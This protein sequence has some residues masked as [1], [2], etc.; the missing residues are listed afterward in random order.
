MTRTQRIKA[1]A[2]RR[3]SR[4]AR[5]EENFTRPLTPGRAGR[6][7]QHETALAYNETQRQNAN[8]IRGSAQ[9]EKQV[10]DWYKTFA[11]E[12]AAS[13]NEVSGAYDKAGQA[14]Q[15]TM[16]SGAAADSARQAQLGQEAAQ[17]SQL[18]GAPQNTT[19]RAT[20]AAAANG[21]QIT[22]AALAAPVA[23]QGANSFAYFTNQKNTA[24]GEGLSQKQKEHQ[25]TIGLQQDRKALLKEKGNYR[26]T[27][28][29]EL[30]EKDR[31]YKIQQAA[32]Q[33]EGAKFGADQAAGAASAAA[34]ARKEA[35]ELRQQGVENRQEQ[36]KIANEGGGNGGGLTPKEKREAGQD[37]N[38]AWSAGLSLFRSE[39]PPKNS[40]EW[41]RFQTHLQQESEVTPAIAA[42]V[43]KK[44]KGRQAQA[45]KKKQE[46]QAHHPW[47]Y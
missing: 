11:D 19:N 40:R 35:N 9:R 28:L 38:N 32:T 26:A 16:A 5:Q 7:A 1:R 23:A 30:R 46:E 3:E 4:E 31:N 17:F 41:A 2:N 10:G 43:V 20:S 18:T 14:I 27:K 47:G 12:I 42:K 6:Q 34:D 29:D 15:G 44:L 33:L 13:R 37:W 25:R 21:R 22:G 36:E 39:A 24:S 45:E 8:L